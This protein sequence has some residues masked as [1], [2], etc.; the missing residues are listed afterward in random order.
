MP[1]PRAA[2]TAIADYTSY[3]KT[4][5]GPAYICRG[6]VGP[7]SAIAVIL[8]TYAGKRFLL[9]LTNAS[10]C[11]ASM[12]VMRDYWT[13]SAFPCSVVVLHTQ[14]IQ[15]YSRFATASGCRASQRVSLT[16]SL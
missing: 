1:K 14:H 6:L 10:W 4:V 16:G 15:P 9:K 5:T 3:L 2:C 8:G 13:L 12:R 11:G 7:P